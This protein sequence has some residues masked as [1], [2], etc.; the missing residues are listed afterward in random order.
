MRR[1]VSRPVTEKRTNK[2]VDNGLDDRVCE[3]VHAGRPDTR[4]TGVTDLTPGR[5]PSGPVH[6]WVTCGRHGHSS[7]P[8][9]PDL[10]SG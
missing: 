7:R 5:T 8:Y 4:L 9:F 3:Y 10:E 6:Q 2:E 1:D